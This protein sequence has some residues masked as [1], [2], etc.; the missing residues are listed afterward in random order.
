MK[1]RLV[2]LLALGLLAACTSVPVSTLWKLARFDR[3]QLLAVDPAQLRA[4]AL[5]DSRAT[6]RDVTMKITL[7]PAGASPA[8]YSIALTAPVDRDA[9][10][11]AAPAGRRWE[12]FALEPAGQR[13]FLRMREAATL[14]PKGS[15][16]TL[17]L[18]AREGNVPPDLM[19]RFPL[20]LELLLDTQ[21]GWFTV[22]KDSELD[23]TRYAGKG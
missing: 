20:R 3:A 9:R 23:L 5:V 1:L 12:I 8:D 14:L 19:Q 18:S 13:E 15:G 4:A 10:L 7:T 11:P 2:R 22:L 6:M 17:S 16:L 21:D